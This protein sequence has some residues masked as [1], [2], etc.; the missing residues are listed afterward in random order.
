MAVVNAEIVLVDS[1]GKIIS[2]TIA[3]AFLPQHM[4]HMI[5]ETG[6]Q[7]YQRKI[8]MLG[9]NRYSTIVHP[10]MLPKRLPKAI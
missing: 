9:E 7:S 6:N 1:D 4:K 2:S 8:I 3:D 5:K 10:L